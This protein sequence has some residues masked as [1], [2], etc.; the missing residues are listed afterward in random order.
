M[1]QQI[2]DRM[3]ANIKKAQQIQNEFAKVY[4]DGLNAE[5]DMEAIEN[6]V[7]EEMVQEVKNRDKDGNLSYFK[8]D[9]SVKLK[10]EWKS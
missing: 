3:K 7:A 4:E 10:A 5:I 6:E 9:N 1:K 8:K 2:K